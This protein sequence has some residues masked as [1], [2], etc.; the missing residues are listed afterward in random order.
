MKAFLLSG[1]STSFSALVFACF[2]TWPANAQQRTHGAALE[3]YFD[4]TVGDTGLLAIQA[5]SAALRWHVSGAP[6]HPVE[7]LMPFSVAGGLTMAGGRT[8]VA[9]GIDDNGSGV[10]VRMTLTNPYIADPEAKIE[11]VQLLGPAIDPLS[12]RW[13]EGESRLYLLD[14]KAN[15]VLYASYGGN[16]A[17]LPLYS[18]LV[19]AVVLP[20]PICDSTSLQFSQNGESAGVFVSDPHQP[21]KYVHVFENV[22]GTWEAQER[23]KSVSDPPADPPSWYIANPSFVST[24]GPLRIFARAAQYD[25][26]EELSG[27]SV[28]SGTTVDADV[29]H[30]VALPQ[31]ALVPGLRYKVLTSTDADGGHARSA[32]FL[33][34]VR[35]GVPTETTQ[36]QLSRGYCGEVIVGDDTFG[37]GDRVLWQK[38][39]KEPVTAAV[40]LWI[41]FRGADGQ[42]RVVSLGD[43]VYVLDPDALYANL[44]PQS[45]TIENITDGSFF[46]RLPVPDDDQLIGNTILFQSA[47][48]VPSTGDVIVSDVFGV[49]IRAHGGVGAALGGRLLTR[50]SNPILPTE[51]A[52]AAARRWIQ[53]HSPE[54]SS[55][56]RSE[57]RRLQERL[58]RR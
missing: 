33:P 14:R 18:S 53:S 47:A 34:H 13:N 5:G 38:G 41:S 20:E 19:E 1:R 51:E 50:G 45:V 31:G 32:A 3:A 49:T 2:T 56:S 10:L 58:R 55:Q 15:R 24:T 57:I 8:V 9:S 17:A 39:Y 23:I 12:V 28:A 11:E 37:V 22:G 35:Y 52:L 26:V 40:Y 44:G 42:D 48:V 29:E 6:A 21:T 27:V 4:P 43:R 46:F 36:V 30:E 25:V 54:S 16:G 7:T